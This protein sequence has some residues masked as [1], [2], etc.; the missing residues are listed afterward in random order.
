MAQDSYI[1]LPA[2]GTGK[3]LRTRQEVVGANTVE[4][5]LVSSS[6]LPTYYAWSG[7]QAFAA[8]KHFLS[9]FNV[10]GSG[11]VVRLKK[12][13]V[14]NLQIGAVTGVLFQFDFRRT[15][16][17]SAGSAITAI[18]MDTQD[19]VPAQ[20]VVAIAAGAT[21]TNSSLLFSQIFSNEENVAAQT[22]NAPMTQAGISWLPEGTEIKELVLRPGEGLTVQNITA[23]TVGSY[24][25]LFVFT[26]E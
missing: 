1:Q 13:F 9:I 4:T 10:A 2:D 15:T 20:S 26:V 14:V 11:K 19:A 3:K 23:T 21:I 5:Q 12:I 25:V 7:A 24:G 17:Q 6:A 18:S 16:A 22:N 8:N